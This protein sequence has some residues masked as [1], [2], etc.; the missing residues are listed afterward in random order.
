MNL[1]SATS[2]APAPSAPSATGPGM[3]NPVAN[4]AQQPS[5]QMGGG[6]GGG[7][8]PPPAAAA[9]MPGPPPKPP[10]P[11]ELRTARA[12]IDAIV[13]GLTG[14]VTKPRGELHKKDVFDAASEMIAKGAFPTPE[15]KQQLIG[16]LAQMPDDEMG[17]RKALGGLLMQA[18][19]VEQGLGHVERSMAPPSMGAPNAV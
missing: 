12:H 2:N 14:L 6:M 15:S 8:P 3:G 18:A 1:L 17:I 19:T 10:T 4:P 5:A 16:E 13:A 11:Q 9:A 7:M